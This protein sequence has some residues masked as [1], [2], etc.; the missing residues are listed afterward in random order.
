MAVADNPSTTRN[1]RT[2]EKKS[3]RE[4]RVSKRNSYISAK[5]SMRSAAASTFFA[6]GAGSLGPVFAAGLGL[7][8]V[9]VLAFGLGFYF[10][11]EARRDSSSGGFGF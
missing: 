9:L 7:A 4:G 8:P 10:T 5:G 1:A 11:P 2:L 3:S 6:G